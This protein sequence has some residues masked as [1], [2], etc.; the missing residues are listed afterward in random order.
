[1]LREAGLYPLRLLAV[2]GCLL[3]LGCGSSPTE[4][5][6]GQPRQVMTAY[7]T[8]T[9]YPGVGANGAPVLDE[10][11][12]V[13]HLEQ[14]HDRAVTRTDDATTR[15]LLTAK[16]VDGITVR[17]STSFRDHYDEQTWTMY[18]SS[19]WTVGH[20]WQHASCYRLGLRGDCCT[21]QDH[22]PGYTLDCVAQ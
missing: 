5:A 17:P 1:V 11:A 7:G 10:A 21:L 14:G 22:R 19:E 18:V 9:L 16:R 3:C 12:V 2:V 13:R 4:T 20:E 15:A 8:I 6:A